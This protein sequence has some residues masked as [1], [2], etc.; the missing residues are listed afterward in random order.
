[1]RGSREVGSATVNMAAAGGPGRSRRASITLTRSHTLAC[2]FQA[3]RRAGRPIDTQTQTHR[4]TEEQTHT[5]THRRT[6][7]LA[8]APAEAPPHFCKYGHW[9][10]VNV[11][12][13]VH[14]GH[15]LSA[16]YITRGHNQVYA[17]LRVSG[18]RVC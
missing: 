17:V 13:R 4:H 5:N 6:G 14:T 7:H 9:Q 12:S 2:A 18:V 3:I 16:L 1:M 10:F 11:C 8:P 15:H